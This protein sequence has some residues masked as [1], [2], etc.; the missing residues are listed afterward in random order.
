MFRQRQLL[1]LKTFSLEAGLR[2]G[3]C[4]PPIHGQGEGV[5]PAAGGQT[6]SLGLR[7]QTAAP[8]TLVSVTAE[9]PLSS[10]APRDRV[11]RLRAKAVY[12]HG[13]N[14]GGRSGE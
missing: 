12:K 1:A 13:K 14:S 3:S 7:E 2:R 5:P 9:G 10:L 8:L 11:L 6:V 4:V